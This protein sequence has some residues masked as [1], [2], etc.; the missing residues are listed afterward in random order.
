MIKVSSWLD[1][2][3]K[4]DGTLI[5]ISANKSHMKIFTIMTSEIRMRFNVKLGAF[6]Y[7]SRF[8]RFKHGVIYSNIEVFFSIYRIA[9]GGKKGSRN[10]HLWKH[11]NLKLN[12]DFT[13]S[14]ISNFSKASKLL[15]WIQFNMLSVVYTSQI[16]ILI[17]RYYCSFAK[18]IEISSM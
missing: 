2:N 18:D 8:L 9:I 12:F 10:D 3:S 14:S 6:Y 4:R 15:R 7:F 5:L 13:G 1:I 17:R 11:I 16:T